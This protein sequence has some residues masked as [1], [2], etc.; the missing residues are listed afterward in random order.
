MA[1]SFALWLNGLCNRYSIY[2]I[3]LGYIYTKSYCKG[4]DD[5]LS[6][7]RSWSDAVLERCQSIK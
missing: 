6:R 5:A 4:S 3:K 2:I 7:R 1:R